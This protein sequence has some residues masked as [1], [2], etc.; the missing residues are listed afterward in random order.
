MFQSIS[1]ASLVSSRLMNDNVLTSFIEHHVCIT[2]GSLIYLWTRPSGRWYDGIKHLKWLIFQYNTKWYSIIFRG[3]QLSGASNWIN[4]SLLHTY[5]LLTTWIH[6]SPLTPYF[7]P[8]SNV[9][10]LAGK[11]ILLNVN[12]SNVFLQQETLLIL[13]N[14]QLIKQL[15]RDTFS[16]T[17]R[18]EHL[19]KDKYQSLYV[20]M[21]HSNSVHL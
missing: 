16:I 13:S 15:F 12:S 9:N 20:T 17:T 5:L 19:R 6:N 21:F 3:N 10:T 1:L 14:H 18:Q 11:L 7:D 2:N 8:S 4:N